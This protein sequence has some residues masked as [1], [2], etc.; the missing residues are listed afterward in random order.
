MASS[1]WT[2]DKV[3]AVATMELKALTVNLLKHI[4]KKK[5]K[6]KKDTK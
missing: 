6:T 5:E 3:Q 4:L 1:W 2:K